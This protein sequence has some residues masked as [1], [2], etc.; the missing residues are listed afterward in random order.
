[1]RYTAFIFLLL[2]PAMCHAQ[3][4]ALTFQQAEKQGI[5]MQKLD[6]LYANALDADTAKAV[7]KGAEV[8]VFYKAYTT[9]LSDL[10][11]FLQ[12][13]NFKWEKPTR[14]FHRIYFE[15]DGNIDHYLLNLQPTSMDAA[16]QDTLIKQVNEFAKNY[17]LAITANKKFAQ[18]SPAIYQDAK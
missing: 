4:K 2:I 6:K 15:P 11:I 8:Q 10:S 3:Q 18:C 12:K 13:N 14:I 1:M 9:M 16:K 17:K 5:A 7:F